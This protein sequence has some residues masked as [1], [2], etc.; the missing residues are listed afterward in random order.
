M[1]MTAHP[2]Q[3]E[4][5]DSDKRQFIGSINRLDGKSLSGSSPAIGGFFMRTTQ[6]EIDPIPL[7]A[8]D[9]WLGSVR[10]LRSLMG[11]TARR[12][13]DRR[14]VQGNSYS[15]GRMAL[16]WVILRFLALG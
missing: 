8:K 5:D 14:R 7:A 15:I 6:T 12:S 13:S 1:T 2:I 4:N 3:C 16:S 10:A 11:V 9:L